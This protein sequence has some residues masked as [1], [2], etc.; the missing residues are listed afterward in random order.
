ML[1]LKEMVSN[2]DFN[3]DIFKTRKNIENKKEN[4]SYSNLEIDL[5]DESYI[6]LQKYCR[7]NGVSE[8]DF[9]VDFLTSM[10]IGFGCDN[11]NIICIDRA[12]FL[13]RFDEIKDD[14]KTYKVY[15]NHNLDN[16]DL[17]TQY[18]EKDILFKYLDMKFN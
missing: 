11:K 13:V 4:I 2:Y 17:V 14:K 16:F 18:N 6:A 10:V 7:E 5:S 8:E 12:T 15:D 3:K 9:L 1:D